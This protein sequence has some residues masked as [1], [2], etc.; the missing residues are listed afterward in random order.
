MSS[1]DEMIFDPGMSFSENSDDQD[2]VLFNPEQLL[3]T[4]E[5][6]LEGSHY[7]IFRSSHI[8]AWVKGPL[9]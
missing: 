5:E 3:R 4:L 2:I 6:P 1:V 8:P 7:Q 9:V